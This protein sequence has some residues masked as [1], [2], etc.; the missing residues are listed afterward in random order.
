[1]RN[2]TLSSY[3]DFI[4]PGEY[5]RNSRFSHAANYLFGKHLVSLVDPF[6]GAGPLNIVVEH[7]THHNIDRVIVGHEKVIFD[8]CTY[9]CTTAIRYDS[10]LPILSLSDLQLI[11]NNLPTFKRILKDCALAKSIAF[12]FDEPE[13]LNS[14]SSFESLLKKRFHKGTKLIG[15][16]RVLEAVRTM[17]GLGFGLTPSGDDFISG[18]VLGLNLQQIPLKNVFQN[19]IN[20]I[21]VIAQSENPLSRAW[22]QCSIKGRVFEKMKQVIRALGQRDLNELL[23]AVHRLLTVGSTSGIDMAVGLVFGMEN[24]VV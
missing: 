22:L 13:E 2:T 18:F 5:R 3:G 14:P 7:E 21:F 4:V 11:K 15:E 9:A 20:D 24:M 10:S 6:I 17:R 19:L 16:G 1:V 23:R 12:L 8:D